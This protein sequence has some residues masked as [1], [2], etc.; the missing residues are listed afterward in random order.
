LG[1]AVGTGFFSIFGASVCCVVSKAM[2]VQL[3]ANKHSFMQHKG[4]IT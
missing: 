2:P 4:N 1:L 3:Q